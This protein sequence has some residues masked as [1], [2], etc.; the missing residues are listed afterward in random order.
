MK[1]YVY[2]GIKLEG[3][4]P[5]VVRKIVPKIALDEDPTAI[6]VVRRVGGWKGD[7]TLRRVYLQ[8][9]HRAS[10]ARWVELLLRARWLAAFRPYHSL[11]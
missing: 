6:E 2:R 1:N 11:P 7:K 3:F 10:Q 9:R 4:H 8:K 5:H